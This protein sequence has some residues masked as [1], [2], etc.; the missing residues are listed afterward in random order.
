MRLGEALHD[1]A[2]ASPP[3]EVPADLFDRAWRVRRRRRFQAALAIVVLSVAVLTVT[4]RPGGLT[5]QPG[6]N[7]DGLPSRVVPPP[8]LSADIDRAPLDAA[9]VVFAGP[10]ATES[11]LGDHS[12]PLTLVGAGD[13]YRVY[14]RPEWTTATHPGRTFLLSP[15]GR[16][17]AGGAPEGSAA[18]LANVAV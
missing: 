1:V 11:A 15:N 9:L 10:A 17:L 16:Y 8:W 2:G 14:E 7:P 13:Q 18:P 6:Q 12:W 4:G 3:L 5:V